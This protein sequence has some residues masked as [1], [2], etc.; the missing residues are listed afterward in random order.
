MIRVRQPLGLLCLAVAA[1]SAHANVW[2]FETVQEGSPIIEVSRQALVHDQA[3]RPHYFYGGSHLYHK[4]FD[5]QAWQR[6]VVDPLPRTGRFARAAVGPDGRFHIAYLDEYS[7]PVGRRVRYAVG[8]TGSWTTENIPGLSD[9]GNSELFDSIAVD[10]AGRAYVAR[11]VCTDPS[12]GQSPAIVLFTRT[13]TSWTSEI[14]IA[15]SGCISGG[16]PETRLVSVA[17]DSADQPH[18]LYM[19]DPDGTLRHSQKSGGIWTQELVAPAGYNDHSAFARGPGD[20]FYACYQDFGAVRLALYCANNSTGTWQRTLVDDGSDLPETSAG[21]FPSLLIDLSGN[22]H[23]SYY[24]LQQNPNSTYFIRYATNA[25]GSWSH[26]SVATS[27]IFPSPTILGLD[28]AGNPAL[29]YKERFDPSILGPTTDTALK[30]LA[31]NGATWDASDVDTG[32]PMA[33]PAGISASVDI[34]PSG[35]M[36]SAYLFQDVQTFFL[37]YATNKS[38]SWVSEKFGSVGSAIFSGSGKLAPRV[39]AGELGAAHI[40]F[41][42]DSSAS[43]PKYRT[44]RTG[45][46]V[47]SQIP[48]SIPPSPLP[49]VSVSSYVL[50]NGASHVLLIVRAGVGTGAKT[51]LR[52]ATNATGAWSDLSVFDFGNIEVEPVTDL[53]VAD[54]GDVSILFSADDLKFATVKAGQVSVQSVLAPQFDGEWG[55][56]SLAV[57]SSGTKYL[58]FEK[59]ISCVGTRCPIGMY[60]NSD[61]SGQWRE[62][63]VDSE[64]YFFPTGTTDLNS[65]VYFFTPKEPVVS[66]NGSAVKVAYYHDFYRQLRVSS[67]GACGLTS[68]FAT[69]VPFAINSELQYDIAG[70]SFSAI[71]SLPNGQAKMVYYDQGN[72]R[73]VAGQSSPGIS[74]CANSAPFSK[75]TTGQAVESDFVVTN[76]SGMNASVAPVLGFV[77]DPFSIVGDACTAHILAPGAT[78]SVRVR[79]SATVPSVEPFAVVYTLDSGYQQ[80]ILANVQGSTIAPPPSTSGGGGGGR[81]FIAT[82]AFGSP[83]AAEVQYLRKFRDRYLLTNRPGRAFVDLYY[84]YSP[85]VADFLKRHDLLRS[86]VRYLLIPIVEAVKPMVK[87]EITNERPARE[88]REK[89]GY[90]LMP[91]AAAPARQP[92]RAR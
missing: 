14:A 21:T 82:A 7:N 80:A 45:T 67:R 60:L 90:V 63:V 20:V 29:A 38:G 74:L 24:A 52:Y 79:Y 87:D 33:R 48:L 27:L 28:G 50:K 5:G 36:H 83:L 68:V 44:N 35:F 46:W 1:A 73:L 91:Q 56:R 53:A 42:D 32:Y 65:I 59:F 47:E 34:D 58:A 22:V 13:G 51:E 39:R 41:V 6:E 11:K 54:N 57:T 61:E 88:P 30:R 2:T 69:D 8:G 81:C 3:G 17:I 84:R 70:R 15:L 10:S 26:R 12:F 62:S 4:Y 85:P 92:S 76:D 18:L 43:T 77:S 49:D 72:G 37:E 40:V 9:A 64:V 31:W 89:G 86:M 55:R 78:C 16:D 25:G 19:F 66:V 71:Y 23:V 75:A